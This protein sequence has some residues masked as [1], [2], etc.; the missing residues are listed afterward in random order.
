MTDVFNQRADIEKRRRLR[1]NATPAEQ[2]VWQRLRDRQVE[3]CKFRR[4]YSVDAFVL[5]FYCPELRLAIEIDGDSHNSEE[6]VAY[7]LA[8]QRTIE[9]LGIQFLRFTNREVSGQLDT[10]IEQIAQ[11]LRDLRA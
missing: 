3:N 9:A 5:D 1:Q 10:V 2:L 4:Q 7:D 11:T 6:A 8:R